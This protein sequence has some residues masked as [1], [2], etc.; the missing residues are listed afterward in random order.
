MGEPEALSS[1]SRI[2]AGRS[3]AFPMDGSAALIQL[4]NPVRPLAAESNAAAAKIALRDIGYDVEVIHAGRD[5]LSR[6]QASSPRFA[7]P[8]VSPGL[9]GDGALQDLLDLLGLS[10]TGSPAAVVRACAD[11]VAT[12]HTLASAGLTVLPHAVIS[13]GAVVRWTDGA[14]LLDAVRSLATVVV[15]KPVRG[16]GGMGVKLIGPSDNVAAHVLAALNYDHELLVE[17]YTLGREFIVVVVGEGA[18][19]SCLGAAEV[20]PAD[21][22][23]PGGLGYQRSFRPQLPPDGLESLAV[24]A[25]RAMGCRDAA[26]IDFIVDEDGQPWILEVDTAL[27]YTFGGA[28]SCAAASTESSVGDV[29]AQAAR[30]VTAAS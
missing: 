29:I 27:D 20:I 15:V 7:V 8:C 10:Y 23:Q 16:S 17:P 22:A 18:D 4:P 3:F 19:A 1:G 24:S 6:L 14:A 26:A 2:V 25:F 11:K 13:D 21:H 5:L 12:K 30:R 9:A 28:I